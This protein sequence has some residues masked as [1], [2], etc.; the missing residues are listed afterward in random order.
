MTASPQTNARHHL[1]RTP[2]LRAQLQ[3]PDQAWRQLGVGATNA[4]GRIP[5]LLPPG[6]PLQPGLYRLSF[7][8]HL[9]LGAEAFYPQI[10]ISFQIVR[11]AVAS[12]A[13]ARLALRRLYLVWLVLLLRAVVVVSERP[14]GVVLR[15]RRGPTSC[16]S[17]STCRSS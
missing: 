15:R 12:V 13:A 3:Q 6:H 5:D 8:A 11:G 2:T 7:A 14:R 16:R 10:A 1:P 9:Y 4:D 17:T